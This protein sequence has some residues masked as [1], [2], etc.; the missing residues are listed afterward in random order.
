MAASHVI[1]NRVFS[2]RQRAFKKRILQV[3]CL[4]IDQYTHTSL[5]RDNLLVKIS[6]LKALYLRKKTLMYLFELKSVFIEHHGLGVKCLKQIPVYFISHILQV[7]MFTGLHVQNVHTRL[8]I[9][10]MHILL[11]S[12]PACKVKF[13]LLQCHPLFKGPAGTRLMR[14]LN[15]D[16][17]FMHV[18]VC[19]LSE[20]CNQTYMR[21]LWCMHRTNWNQNA[22]MHEELTKE[23]GVRIVAGST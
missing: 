14:H 21:T 5:F 6:F 2:R 22:Y 9:P 4:K 15:L 12:A 10:S 19:T 13:A 20:N 3:N 7:A 8:G 16:K 23:F 17:S 11:L 18:H 1:Y